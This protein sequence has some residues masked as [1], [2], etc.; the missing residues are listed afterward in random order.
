IDSRYP[1]RRRARPGLTGLAQ[2]SGCRGLAADAAS[3]RART[4]FDVEYVDNWSLVLDL[5]IIF[6]T[7]LILLRL[8]SDQHTAPISWRR[9][10]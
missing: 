8:K 1:H 4:G 6:K 3:V 2:V 7:V 5:K 9:A 10:Y